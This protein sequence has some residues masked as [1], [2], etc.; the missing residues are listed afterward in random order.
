MRVTVKIDSATAAEAEAFVRAF[1]QTR[2]H[3]MP[4]QTPMVP[5]VQIMGIG[6]GIETPALYP[7]HANA[8]MARFTL[9]MDDDGRIR[10]L[11]DP[12]QV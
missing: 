2:D 4:G 8:L 1:Q 10:T 9:N 11:I 5:T 12:A 7:D 3:G 6:W